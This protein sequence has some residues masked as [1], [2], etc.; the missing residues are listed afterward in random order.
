M[1]VLSSCSAL[2][3]H[4]NFKAHMRSDIGRSV[5]DPHTWAGP[6][7]EPINL[8][9]LPSGNVENE[10]EFRGT[11]RYF[12]EYNPESRVIVGWHFEGRDALNGDYL[13]YTEVTRRKSKWGQSSQDQTKFHDNGIG[14]PELKFIH[15]S[16]REMVFD[17]DNCS[18]IHGHQYRG[19][20]N[21]MNP[22]MLGGNTRGQN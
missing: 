10:Y 17:G 5:D 21:Y 18:I 11:C 16:G 2:T 15:P 8:K 13:S 7:F 20:Y 1:L 12:F 19:T 6:R 22:Y 3:P 9:E 4:E 14:E